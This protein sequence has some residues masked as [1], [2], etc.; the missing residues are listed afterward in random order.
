MTKENSEKVGKSF[1]FIVKLKHPESY[2][3]KEGS[4]TTI[5]NYWANSITNSEIMEN[6]IELIVENDQGVKRKITLPKDEIKSIEE[7]M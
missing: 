3:N 4:E 5:F 7:K 2:V 1:K 6:S